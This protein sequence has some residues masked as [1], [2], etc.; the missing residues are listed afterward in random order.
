[1]CS[2]VV[3]DSEAS[4]SLK[5]AISTSSLFNTA[6]SIPRVLSK[7]NKNQEFTKLKLP[8]TRNTITF[9][10]CNFHTRTLLVFVRNLYLLVY[11]FLYSPLDKNLIKME[12]T[13]KNNTY[14]NVK[15]T[16]NVYEKLLKC[17]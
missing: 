1:M 5:S 4:S 9:T 2:S 16:I 3:S 6:S 17:I 12:N 13:S 11:Q 14:L 8:N 7:Q 15:T 10:N